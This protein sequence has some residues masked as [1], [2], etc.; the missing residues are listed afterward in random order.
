MSISDIHSANSPATVAASLVEDD[1]GQS[2]VHLRHKKKNKEK[3]M[4]G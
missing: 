1:K 2:I 3:G 4:G